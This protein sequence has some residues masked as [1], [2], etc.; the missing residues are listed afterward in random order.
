MEEE[1]KKVLDKQRSMSLNKA[2]NLLEKVVSQAIT[3][4]NLNK[5]NVGK[6]AELIKI[7]A[8][9]ENIK[10][11]C[12]IDK[13]GL[14][15]NGLE[16]EI[17]AEVKKAI[18]SMCLLRA[19][20]TGAEE[21]VAGREDKHRQVADENDKK[22]D[23]LRQQFKIKYGESMVL[24]GI[25][26]DM[27]DENTGLLK[28]RLEL[29]EEEK[30]LRHAFRVDMEGLKSVHN[31]NAAELIH[32]LS[33]EVPQKLEI[34]EKD[35]EKQGETE[36]KRE[37][38]RVEEDC[39]VRRVEKLTQETINYNPGPGVSKY[40][41]NMRI[42]Q[43]RDNMNLEK[44]KEKLQR[45]VE[46]LRMKKDDMD[47]TLQEMLKFME[48]LQC[49]D[50]DTFYLKR[51]MDEN[52]K[53]LMIKLDCQ[54]M[55]EIE[56]EEEKLKKAVCK[57]EMFNEQVKKSIIKGMSSKFTAIN[58]KIIFMKNTFA[59]INHFLV[60]FEKFE[61]G[62][63]D[64]RNKWLLDVKGVKDKKYNVHFINV[65]GNTLNELKARE[66][67]IANITHEL[68]DQLLEL[69]EKDL[70]DTMLQMALA[71][72]LNV[73]EEVDFAE[74]IL[75]DRDTNLKT[76]NDLELTMTFWLNRQK[77]DTKSKRGTNPNPSIFEILGIDKKIEYYSQLL[78][79]VVTSFTSKLNFIL[80]LPLRLPA[81]LVCPILFAYP[82]VFLLYILPKFAAPEVLEY[83]IL[84]FFIPIVVSSTIGA[85]V[86]LRNVFNADIPKSWIVSLNISMVCLV[87]VFGLLS[88]EVV[89]IV[90]LITASMFTF[91]MV[92]KLISLLY[93]LIAG[94][95]FSI[96]GVA[97]KLW[98]INLS[99]M[100]VLALS[101]ASLP[102]Y[103]A[104]T[105]GCAIENFDMREECRAVS[106]LLLYMLG[107]YNFHTDVLQDKAAQKLMI[108][109]F[110]LVMCVLVVLRSYEVNTDI[111]RVVNIMKQDPILARFYH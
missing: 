94:K 27:R 14:E 52:K 78:D 57:F 48:K 28:R 68:E 72:V 76:L 104:E 44:R 13:P 109:L 56:I 98:W 92:F 59:S 21:E 89:F 4:T 85:L 29:E 86:L 5:K 101:M 34:I 103:I 63:G 95:D 96:T 17:K 42:T 7:K 83:R 12:T 90:F 107:I 31:F 55:D 106:V 15:L 108:G 60:K 8:Q 37:K 102:H 16:D 30:A 22:I 40:D 54:T 110:M 65:L 1:Q 69:S 67:T 62:I 58:T 77:L 9:L 38:I 93:G 105:Y 3:I 79:S 66:E 51:D 49:S 97:V 50:L 35:M 84:T 46:K 26:S 19:G 45:D 24:P 36:S 100:L 18:D 87:A 6:D 47:R 70:T 41:V 2:I 61:K 53:E 25:V 32:A 80:G 81:F 82:H 88:S 111:M 39:L 23:I 43:I 10:A 91:V 33:N 64:K 99:C 71:K 20:L 11:R 75:G 74:Y 73:K